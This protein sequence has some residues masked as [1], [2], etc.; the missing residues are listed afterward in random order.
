MSEIKNTIAQIHDKFYI[1]II[2]DDISMLENLEVET[3]Q[4]KPREK[5]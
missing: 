3:T 1:E 2:Q 4:R 5:N